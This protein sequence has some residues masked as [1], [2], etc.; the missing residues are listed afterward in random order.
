[1]IF[2]RRRIME[3]VCVEFV[4]KMKLYL[5]V[6]SYT[7]VAF[8]VHH[9]HS[10]TSHILI[11][12][13]LELELRKRRTE[14]EIFRR[15]IMESVCVEPVDK[16]KLYLQAVSYTRVAFY[17]HR[18]HSFTSHILIDRVI[19]LELRKRRTEDELFRRRIMESVCVEPVDEMKSDVSELFAA[20]AARGGAG[21]ADSSRGAASGSGTRVRARDRTF[22]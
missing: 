4:D 19:E 18:S 15:R 14:D 11:D 10:F 22:R 21:G 13:V 20:A 6:V 9:S 16:T 1:M 12:R 17:V 2:R 8:H 7:R 3:S 5:L